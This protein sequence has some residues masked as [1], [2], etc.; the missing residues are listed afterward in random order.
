M[1]IFDLEEKIHGAWQTEEDLDLLLKPT[2]ENLTEDEL[3]NMIS[4]VKTLHSLR[5]NDLW[6]TF[7]R[8]VHS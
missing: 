6:E 8:Y 3:Y 7:E 2:E 4:A 5:M 1:T